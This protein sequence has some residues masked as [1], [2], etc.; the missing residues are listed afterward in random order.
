M[1]KIL[2]DFG[3]VILGSLIM[4]FG[5]GTFLLPNKLSTGGFTGIATIFYY[6]FKIPMSTSII[7]LNIPLFIIAYFKIGRRFL[8]ETIFATYF[9]SKMIDIF[10]LLPAF[11]EDRFLSSIYGGG[12]VG[13]GLGMIFKGKGSTGGS[14]L[15]V[16]IIKSFS[17]KFNTSNLLVFI[18]I[19]IIGLNL[20]VFGEIE[21]GLY[22]TMAIL[23]AGK[24]I[25]I[26]FE[27]IN[28]SKTLYIISNNADEIAKKI[29]TEFEVGATALY[30]RGIYKN[31]EK[32]I[33][34][35]ACKRRNVILVKD[36]AL[37]ID[38]NAFIIISDAREVYG[39]RF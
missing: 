18:D 4:A 12:L 11:T 32:T 28:F 27:G 34:M 2:K 38:P 8:L 25:D 9:Y 23:V 26:I 17:K 19:V 24:L 29:M 13:I 21:I 3:F 22:S 36:I 30:G 33:I 31:Q 37:V 15:L 6:F 39:L 7:I 20:I 1:R 16:T 10:V 35:C 14:D 5:T